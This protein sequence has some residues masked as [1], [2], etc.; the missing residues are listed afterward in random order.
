[1]RVVNGRFSCTFRPAY[2]SSYRFSATTLGGAAGTI[3][4]TV[5]KSGTK[6]VKVR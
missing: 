1:V 3:V 6:T 2:R 4:Y 5:S